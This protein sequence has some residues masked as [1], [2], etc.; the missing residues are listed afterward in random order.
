MKYLLF[1][2]ALILTACESVQEALANPSTAEAINTAARDASEA[3]TSGDWSTAET[4]G[5]AALST[6][7]LATL[8]IWL[9]KRMLN[10]KPG[11]VLGG[12]APG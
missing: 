3:A 10:S 4:S 8:G 6:I 9:R 2:F 1:P 5:V 11:E 12:S 7:V